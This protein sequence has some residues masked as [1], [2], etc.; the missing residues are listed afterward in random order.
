MAGSSGVFTQDAED[1]ALDADIGGGR[2]DGS[3]LGIG[4][5]EADHGALAIEALEGGVG[6]VDKGDDNLSLAG[7]VSAFDEDVVSGD[8]VLVAHGVA[9]DF[10]CEDFAV[11]DDIGQ[12]DALG[13]L[14]GLDGLSGGDASQQRQAVSTFFAGAGW[15]D[16]DRATAIVGAL[17]QTFILQVGDVLM[18]GGERAEAEAGGDLLVGRGVAVLLRKAGEEVDD[19]FLPS[20]DSHGRIVANKRRTG[21]VLFW[22]S[23]L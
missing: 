16:V 10:E 18:D 8:D 4:G 11:A 9:T 20:C 2:V 7:G 17:Q 23:R 22:T 14:D 1:L 3:H 15:Q 19:L 5:L 12:R 13:G 21:E 6:A